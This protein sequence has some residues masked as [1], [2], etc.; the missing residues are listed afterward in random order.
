MRRVS[1]VRLFPVT[2]DDDTDVHVSASYFQ[3]QGVD[4]CILFRNLVFIPTTAENPTS[5]MYEDEK[6]SS[7]FKAS[8]ERVGH[9][10]WKKKSHFKNFSRPT[11]LGNAAT[12]CLKSNSLSCFLSLIKKLMRT[13]NGFQNTVLYCMPFHVAYLTL[14]ISTTFFQ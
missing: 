5:Q 2:V 14:Y 8:V 6:G 9:V 3:A 12:R 1:L 11:S 10:C 13:K 4:N 7:T